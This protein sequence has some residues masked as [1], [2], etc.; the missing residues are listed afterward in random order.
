MSARPGSK[1]DGEMIGRPAGWFDV[2]IA[3]RLV[4]FQVA[5]GFP[6]DQVECSCSVLV[7]CHTA[8]WFMGCPMASCLIRLARRLR[9]WIAFQVIAELAACPTTGLAVLILSVCLAG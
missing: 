7:S 3:S 4:G 2:W 5:A 1:N 6:F 8:G 9:T